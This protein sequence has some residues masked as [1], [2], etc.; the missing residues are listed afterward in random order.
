MR[1]ISLTQDKFTLVDDED[2]DLLN[3]YKWFWTR[4]KWGG[5]AGRRKEGKTIL[6][7]RFIMNSPKGM[8]I[9]HAN[10]DSL[11]NRR[12]NL[13]I[14]SRSENMQNMSIPSHNTSGFKGVVWHKIAKKWMV[15]IKKDKKRQYLGLYKDKLEAAHRY[16]EI[17]EQI[18]GKYA[19]LNFGGY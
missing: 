10:N 14:C 5:Y 11:D 4:N 18:F 16:D 2:F 8:E 12:S 9:D 7:H 13:R 19:K 1:T 3:Q 6:M 15:Q 17:A